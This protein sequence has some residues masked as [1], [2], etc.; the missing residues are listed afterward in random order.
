MDITFNF[1]ELR[2][3]LNRIYEVQKLLF[4]QIKKEFDYG[5]VPE[6]H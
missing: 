6:Y 5:Y 2:N 3:D 4:Y 1:K